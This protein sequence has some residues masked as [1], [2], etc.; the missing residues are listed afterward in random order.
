[1]LYETNS[2]GPDKCPLAKDD[3]GSHSFE[4]QNVKYSTPEVR[5]YGCKYCSASKTYQVVDRADKEE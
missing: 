5:K 2:T 4:L 1:M 3:E